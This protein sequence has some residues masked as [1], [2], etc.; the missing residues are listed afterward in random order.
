ML[1]LK[2]VFSCKLFAY[3]L[4]KMWDVISYLI[5]LGYTEK[6]Y[7]PQDIHW[8]W[9]RRWVENF[10]SSTELRKYSQESFV[11]LIFQES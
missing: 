10:W 3:F 5:I 7:W 6:E 4:L 1:S 8:R 2:I 9:L 11:K